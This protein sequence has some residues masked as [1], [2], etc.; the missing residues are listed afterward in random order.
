MKDRTDIIYG[1]LL[2]AIVV[3]GL[4]VIA[5]GEQ[6]VVGLGNAAN[7]AQG[8]SVRSAFTKVNNNFTELYGLVITNGVNTVSSTAELALVDPSVRT[9]LQWLVD[10]NLTAGFAATNTWAGTNTTTFIAS[11][12]TNW[13]WLKVTPNLGETPTSVDGAGLVFGNNPA[14]IQ[15]NLTSVQS[16]ST[17]DGVASFPIT[18]DSNTIYLTDPALAG[19]FRL[20]DNTLATYTTNSWQ[21]IQSTV[22]ADWIWERMLSD[23]AA[24]YV[25]TITDLKGLPVDQLEYAH[26][27]GSQGGL[28]KRVAAGSVSVDEAGLI[29]I[30]T[31]DA[32]FAWSRQFEGVAN[33]LWFGLVADGVTDDSALLKTI[34]VNVESGTT[35]LFPKRTYVFDNVVITNNLSFKLDGATFLHKPS[36]TNDMLKLESSWSGSLIGPGTIDGNRTNRTDRDAAPIR[37]NPAGGVIKNL[38]FKSSI[39]SAIEMN[40]FNGKITIEDCQFTDIAEHNGVAGDTTAAIRSIGGSNGNGIIRN[41]YFHAASPPA[42]TGMSP[43]GIYSSALTGEGVRW[44]IENNMFDGFGQNAVAAANF[45]GVIDFYEQNHDSIVQNN[46]I[47][48]WYFSALKMSN[49]RHL[50]IINNVIEDNLDTGIAHGINYQPATRAQTPPFAHGLI[51]GNII[52]NITNGV[53]IA[54]QGSPTNGDVENLILRDNQIRD[55][56]DG[57]IFNYGGGEITVGGLQIDGATDEGVEFENAFDGVVNFSDVHITGT[58]TGMRAQVFPDLRLTMQSSYIETSSAC[59]VFGD[60]QSLSLMGNHFNSSG[61]SAM[62]IQR[63]GQYVDIGNILVSGTDLR[64]LNNITNMNAFV[65]EVVDGAGGVNPVFRSRV[66][67][68]THPKFQIHNDGDLY[69]G[70]GSSADSDTLMSRTGVGL[71]T[72]ATGDSFGITDGT[73]NGGNFRMGAYYLWVDGSGR[74]RIKS[75]APASDTDGTIVGTQL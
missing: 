72:M 36:T 27:G 2:I 73:W 43:G 6:E 13:A 17:L 47:T 66:T 54:V 65:F 64:S 32:N 35:V 14:I 12:N 58:A 3:T 46:I 1:W 29:F 28:F 70:N 51:S 34:D 15:N 60:F 56:K 71:I 23:A 62:N 39:H 74:L 42:A 26:V 75:G 40:T 67:G 68:N 7:D 18:S 37:V 38:H 25:D 33:A 50:Q 45:L 19:A 31:I 22:D 59:V 30:S 10:G 5:R 44:V 11:T 61:S 53:G 57:L 21:Y 8:D 20:R 41:C 69:W 48:N 63:I 4:V 9:G 16:V 52:R 49:S 55:V 24:Q